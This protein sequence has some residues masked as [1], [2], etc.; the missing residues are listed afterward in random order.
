M[1]IISPDNLKEL[2]HYEIGDFIVY[3]YRCRG[4]NIYS[5]LKIE[6]ITRTKGT[7]LAYGLKCYFSNDKIAIMRKGSLC[8]K[9]GDISEDYTRK[10][11][12]ADLKFYKKWF[13]PLIKA[14]FWKEV[15]S[16]LTI[17]EPEV[18]DEL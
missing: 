3:D 17:R 16:L 6:E 13:L 12:A 5:I 2:N 7:F 1:T 14:K 15:K 11:T 8:Y 9:I 4:Y 10:A 18:K